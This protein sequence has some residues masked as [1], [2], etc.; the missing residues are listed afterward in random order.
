VYAGA[1]LAA[2]YG[3]E[4]LAGILLHGRQL[5][6]QNEEQIQTQQGPYDDVEYVS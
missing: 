1:Q 6:G 3:L 4:A 2:Q 5:E